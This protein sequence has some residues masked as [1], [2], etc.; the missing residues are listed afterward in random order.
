MSSTRILVD[1][2]PRK[3]EDC[4][5]SEFINMT[6]KTKCI[7]MKGLYSRCNLECSKKCDKLRALFEPGSED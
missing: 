4:P 2:L 3:P 6:S 7:L 1:F 5:F